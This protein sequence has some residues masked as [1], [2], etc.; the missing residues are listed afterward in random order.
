MKI[1]ILALSLCLFVSMGVHVEKALSE[2]E[3]FE[4]NKEGSE[5][6]IFITLENPTKPMIKEAVQKGFYK[7]PLGKQYPKLQIKTIDE[8]LKDDRL[9]LPTMHISHKKAQP[10]DKSEQIKL[11]I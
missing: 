2:I 3:G 10:S 5:I 7:S 8:L 9:D 4:E 11:E 6:G 1:F